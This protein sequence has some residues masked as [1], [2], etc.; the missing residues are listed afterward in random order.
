MVVIEYIFF[1]KENT[2][3]PMDEVVAQ[4]RMLPIPTWSQHILIL[5]KL[6]SIEHTG[7]HTGAWGTRN[8]WRILE[9]MIELSN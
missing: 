8:C 4:L 2:D 7:S 5:E 6:K 3:Y 9:H 1:E